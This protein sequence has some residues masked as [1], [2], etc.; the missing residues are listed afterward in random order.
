[1]AQRIRRCVR[2][3]DRVSIQS[4]AVGASRHRS[5]DVCSILP[6]ELLPRQR[7]RDSAAMGSLLPPDLALL[8]S[9]ERADRAHQSDRAIKRAL[10][11]ANPASR[12]GRR[13]LP[14]A[15]AALEKAGVR[16]DVAFTE[17]PGHAA[18]IVAERGAGYD[19]VFTLGG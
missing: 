3:E 14:R 11:V 13:R 19:A 18:E 15:R 1:S 17:R 7:R 5:T 9:K 8:N 2:R 6:F 12:L 16:C 4:A 10:L